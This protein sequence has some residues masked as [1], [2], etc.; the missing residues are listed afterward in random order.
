MSALAASPLQMGVLTALE[1][2]AFLV[3]G[4]PA[5]AWVD[6][7]RRKRV[8]GTNDLVKE[9]RAELAAESS[10]LLYWRSAT[11]TAARAFGLDISR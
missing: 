1:T 10:P 3:V 5:G 6:R 8:L 7:W 2:L 9:T 4:L 11:L